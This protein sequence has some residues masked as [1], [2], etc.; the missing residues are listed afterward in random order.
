M[1]REELIALCER[2][3]VPVEQWSDRDSADAQKQVGEAL[4][5]LRAGVEFTLQ[6]RTKDTLWVRCYYPGFTAFEYG[7]GERA[8]LYTYRSHEHHW[9]L[10]ETTALLTDAEQGGEG[11]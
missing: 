6:E 11:H 10:P 4:V 3:V 9:A 1:N 7:R 8:N 5:L 2:A